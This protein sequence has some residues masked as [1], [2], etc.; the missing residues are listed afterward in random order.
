MDQL[1]AG[2]LE[3]WADKTEQKLR[4]GG[5]VTRS[6]AHFQGVPHG[7]VQVAVIAC[8]EKAG[9]ILPNICLHRRSKF[10]KQTRTSGTSWA[11]PGSR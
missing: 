6:V 3:R 5:L 8:K 1:M 11:V 9:K 10:K 7:A 2:I 4:I